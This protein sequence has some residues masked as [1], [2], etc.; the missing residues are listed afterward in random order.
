MNRNNIAKL[1]NLKILFFLCLIYIIPTLESCKTAEVCP[2]IKA[3]GNASSNVNTPDDQ[4]SPFIFDKDVFYTNRNRKAQK[5]SMMTGVLRKDEIINTIPLKDVNIN[6]ISDGGLIKL[7]RKNILNRTFAY[8]AGITTTTKVP[9]SDIYFTYKNDNDS[10]V[11]P[12]MPENINSEYYESYPALSYDGN[13]LVFASDRPGGLGGIDL[14]VSVKNE[15][16]IWSQPINL[17]KDINTEGDDIAPFINLDGSLIYSTNGRNE[18]NTFDV[19]IANE[20]ERGIWRNSHKLPAPINT[21]HNETG[22]SLYNNNIYLSSDR[23]GGCGGY[24]IYTFRHCGDVILEGIVEGE[25]K[26]LPLEGKLYLLDGN[27]ELINVTEIKQDGKF[28]LELQPSNIYYLQ[29]FNSCVPNYVPEQLVIAPCSDTTVVKIM[30][31]FVIPAS[32]RKFD[33]AN[34]KVPFFVSGYYHP[35]TPST[36]DNLRLK[37]AY[38]LIGN[39]PETKYIEKPG[40]Q[41]DD[42]AI[43]VQGALDDAIEHIGRM[44][45]NTNEDCIRNQRSFKIK[46]NGFADPRPISDFSKYADESINDN[47]LKFSIEKNAII[48]NSKLS[49]L[50]AYFT[51][52]YIM[53]KLKPKVTNE[54]FSMIKWEIEG[55]GIDESDKTNELKRRVNIEIGVVE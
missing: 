50:R 49:L 44:L 21:N 37:F 38:N 14:Y 16:G 52:K 48:D 42:F 7:Y 55:L 43:I 23:P 51:A 34:Y 29:Y 45:E 8:F 40:E 54:Q 31:K 39:E 47:I 20:T 1:F 24:D 36:L 4:L 53:T 11:L 17:G 46:V 30:V 26:E 35:N 15:N 13:L 18:S 41:Y 33:F 12:V 32:T 6:S 9:N 27:R 10:W 2:E 3:S 22:A 25:K 5:F 19:F 28:R